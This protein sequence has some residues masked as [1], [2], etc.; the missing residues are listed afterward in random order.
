MESMSQFRSDSIPR[1]FVLSFG[2]ELALEG[3]F[4]TLHQTV[5]N[6]EFSAFE[7]ALNQVKSRFLDYTKNK[8]IIKDDFESFKD[9]SFLFQEEY[10][11]LCAV[12]NLAE[13]HEFMRNNEITVFIYPDNEYGTCVYSFQIKELIMEEVPK[14]FIETLENEAEILSKL[15]KWEEGK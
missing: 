8:R 9:F 1:I 12:T 11:R 3:E 6:S 7:C 5:H 10:K 4:L 15:K 2:A 14:E 13:L